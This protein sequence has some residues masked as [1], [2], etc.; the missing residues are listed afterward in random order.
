MLL[1]RL[2]CCPFCFLQDSRGLSRRLGSLP[3]GIIQARSDLE[4]R[5]LWSTSS[6]RSKVRL[7]EWNASIK[8]DMIYIDTEILGVHSALPSI[9][10]HVPEHELRPFENFRLMS[11]A[12]RLI[13]P[14]TVTYWQC[15]LGSSKSIM[16]MLLSIR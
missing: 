2:F 16:S 1:M 5:P 6:S 4:L 3:R 8:A 15:L 11:L 14:A 12:M 9:A 10:L 13:V 7:G